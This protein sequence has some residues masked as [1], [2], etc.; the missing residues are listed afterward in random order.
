MFFLKSQRGI[1]LAELFIRLALNAILFDFL[2]FCKRRYDWR[3]LC[4]LELDGSQ[5]QHCLYIYLVY[6]T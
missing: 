1:S 4:V 5:T 3:F 2:Q 6:M